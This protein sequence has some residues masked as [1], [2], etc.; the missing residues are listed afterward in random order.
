MNIV[1]VEDFGG[2]LPANS[3]TLISLFQGVVKP[4]TFIRL[5]DDEDDLLADPSILSR[6]FQEHSHDGIVLV[7]G[8]FDYLGQIANG[9]VKRHD[10]FVIDIN[11]DKFVSWGRDLPAGMDGIDEATFHR[12][13]GF[14]I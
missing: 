10:V 4:E 6:F 7:K 9:N 14:Y 13:G 1:W 2:G 3:T 12:K 8:V 5:W 11:L